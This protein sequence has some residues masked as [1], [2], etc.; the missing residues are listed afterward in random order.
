MDE[1]KDQDMNL[2]PESLIDGM[3]FD[4]VNLGPD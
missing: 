1:F 2:L 3:L 4:Q